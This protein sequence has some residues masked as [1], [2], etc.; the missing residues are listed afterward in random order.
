LPATALG[1]LIC[2]AP[3]FLY[4]ARLPVVDEDFMRLVT[5]ENLV[6]GLA[7]LPYILRSLVKEFFLKPHLWSFLGF[8]A[9]VLALRSPRTAVQSRF[10][11]FIWIP[12]LYVA[13][14]C[15]IFMVIP[16]K[17]EEL[18][19]LT[20]T[21]LMMHTA[22]LLFVWICFEFGNSGLVLGNTPLTDKAPSRANL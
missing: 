13:V 16:W 11:F 4:Q 14:L 10:S 1:G 8:S 15:E 17:L 18:F 19:P 7:R 12:A 22:P 21:R 3:W 5:L 20:L 6:G 2:L 9:A